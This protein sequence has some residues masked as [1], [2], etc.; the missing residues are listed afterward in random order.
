MSVLYKILVDSCETCPGGNR[1]LYG[2]Y[3][4]KHDTEIVFRQNIDMGVPANCPM[5][6]A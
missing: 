3:R 4:C 6:S 2:I 1:E 5:R